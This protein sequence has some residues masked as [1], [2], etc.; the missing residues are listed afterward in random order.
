M[1]TNA[2]VRYSAL[3]SASGAGDDAAMSR[4]LPDFLI[5]G[6]PRCGTTWLASALGLHPDLWLARPPRPEPKF[7]L[8]DEL[9][10]QGLD[11]YS[12]RWFAQAPESALAGEKSTNYLESPTAAARIAADLPKVKMIFVLRDPVSRAISNYRWSVHNGK[13]TLGFAAALE[14]EEQRERELSLED[15]YARPHAYFSRGLYARMLRPYL[16]GL[17]RKRVLVLRFEDIM[18]DQSV[19]VSRVHTFLGVAPRPDLVGKADAIN[20][21]EGQAAVDPALVSELRRRYAPSVRE[22][23]ELLDPS[24]RLWSQEVPAP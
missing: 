15:R 19:G 5:G 22:L 18:A 6:A 13:E 7:F 21:S 2:R 1:W 20:P 8:V 3:L 24:F 17:G 12:R 10:A 9:Y 4:R 14:R 16:D 23:A 11:V